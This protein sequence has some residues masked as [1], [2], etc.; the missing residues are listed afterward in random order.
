MKVLNR[1]K[2]SEDFAKAIHKGNSFRLP[3]YIVHVIKTDNGYT[4]IGISASSKL[5]CA[6][7]R[8]RVKR[9]TRAICDSL[10]DYNKKSLDI[11]IIIKHNF[12]VNSFDDN[13]SQL[14]DL[15]KQVGL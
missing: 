7:I 5:G 13:K 3:S 12:L 6:V 4:R 15:T 10:I 11:V 1:I 8:N 2:K 14:S 9:Q